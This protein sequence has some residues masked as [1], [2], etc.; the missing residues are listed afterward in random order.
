MLCTNFNHTDNANTHRIVREDGW[1]VQRADYSLHINHIIIVKSHRA[2]NYLWVTSSVY[3]L[4]LV[5]FSFWIRYLIPNCETAIHCRKSLFIKH[6]FTEDL[7]LYAVL[8]TKFYFIIQYKSGMKA[9]AK[10]QLELALAD[11]DAEFVGKEEAQSTLIE[12]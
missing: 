6:R 2:K 7:Q 10:A 12:L 9:E 4:F 3:I 5:C 1:M 11:A 8:A